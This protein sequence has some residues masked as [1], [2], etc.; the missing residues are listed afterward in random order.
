MKLGNALSSVSAGEAVR[1]RE[2]ITF[3]GGAVVGWP[4]STRA[5]QSAKVPIIGYLSQS[6][7]SRETQ[8]TAAFVRRLNELGWIE[9]SALKIEYR[10]AEEHPEGLNEFAADLV[11]LNLSVIVTNGTPPT[12]AAKRATP[13]SCEQARG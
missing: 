11:G 8:F 4:L 2:F 13:Q 12:I 7:G 9:G 10:W 6:S 1:R 5:Q 3:L